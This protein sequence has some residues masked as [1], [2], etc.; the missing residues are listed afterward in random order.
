MKAMMLTGIRKM[1]MREVRIPSLR[2][3]T[4]VLLK[5][6]VVGVCGSDIHYY[7]KGR[8]G[9]Q[10]VRYPFIVGHE[11]SAVV[12]KIG[13]KVSRVKLGDRVAVEPAMACGQCDQCRAGRPHTCRVLRFLGCPRQ[14]EGCLSEYLVMPHECCYPVGPRTTLEQAALSEPLGIGLYAV[15]QSI[16]LKNKAIAIL[17]CGPIGLSVL[18]CARL[19][20][21]KAVFV[22]D[23]IDRRLAWA[24][25][26]GINWTGHPNKVNVARAI[27]KREPMLLDVVFECCGEQ[28]AID[29]AVDL[30]KPGGKL[31]LI[32]IPS[33][34][35]VSFVM[36][37][38]RRKEITIQNV[39]RQC[40][41]VQ[42]TLDFIERKQLR[43][44]FMVTHRFP[45]SRTKEA[46]DLVAGYRDGVVKAMIHF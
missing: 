46:F 15:R 11:C 10:V 23:K 42:P 29:Q 37:R 27:G 40:A 31:M 39:R 2:T 12:L 4:D 13:R 6:A 38:I 20:K 3:P 1:Q 16:P 30:L 44:D 5:L 21:P 14:A 35:R 9:S 22:T 33:V 8:I 45:F 32:G 18:L 26:T 43:P 25:S 34:E 7:T 36:D 17:G 41:C 24:R 19:Q 28:E